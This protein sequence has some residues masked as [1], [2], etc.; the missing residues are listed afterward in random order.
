M[1]RLSIPLSMMSM[2]FSKQL[3]SRLLVM[4]MISAVL[5]LTSIEL[6]IHA[7]DVATSADQGYAVHISSIAD[8]L[9]PAGASDEIKVSPDGVLK[10][11]QSVFSVLAVFLLAAL[12]AV[13]CCSVC[14]GRLRDT[15]FLL[16][17][18]PFHGTPSLR[19]PPR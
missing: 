17:R 13:F 18:L 6:H 12:L 7:R 5:F 3:S 19:A 10:I 4:Y 1:L 2:K 15:G 8:E 11:S 9:M 16:P 14:I